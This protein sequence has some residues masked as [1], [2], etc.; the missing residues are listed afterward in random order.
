MEGNRENSFTIAELPIFHLVLKWDNVFGTRK[1]ANWNKQKRDGESK[2]SLCFCQN[3]NSRPAPGC[4][5]ILDPLLI[6]RKLAR[7]SYYKNIYLQLSTYMYLER[8]RRYI[9]TSSAISPAL[10]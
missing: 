10:T 2:I 7:T 8:E 9:S 1:S 6:A 5:K 4:A 3:K